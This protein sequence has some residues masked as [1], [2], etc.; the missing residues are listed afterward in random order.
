M[1][2]G[3]YLPEH[4]IIAEWTCGFHTYMN[5]FSDQT[6]EADSIRKTVGVD[7]ARVQSTFISSGVHVCAGKEILES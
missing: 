4:P 5:S 7:W 6:L 1:T 2:N 3:S